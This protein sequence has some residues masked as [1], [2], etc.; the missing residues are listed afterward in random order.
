M[1]T[2][3]LVLLQGD[4][5]GLSKLLDASMAAGKQNVAFLCL[6]LLGQVRGTRCCCL[7]IWLAEYCGYMYG[8]CIC[9]QAAV[10]ALS[11]HMT[12]RSCTPLPSDE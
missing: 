6:F 1:L 9:L 3:L 5:A 12:S 2:A 7:L 10:S 4:R 11:I 8:P